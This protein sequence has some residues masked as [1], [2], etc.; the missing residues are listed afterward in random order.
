MT[1]ST[2]H[3]ANRLLRQVPET[4]R[5]LLSGLLE[6]IDLDKGFQLA[7][8]DT[9]IDYVYFLETGVGSIVARSP[10]G[11]EAEAGLFG[12]EGFGPTPPAL[13]IDRNPFDIFV[14]VPGMG[15][16]LPLVTL[17]E[18]LAVSPVFARLL[19]CFA[20]VMS[21]QI[22][23]TGLSNAVHMIDERLARWLLMC[24]DRTDGDEI[25]LTHEFL[26]LMLAVRRPSVTTALHT[27]EGNRFIYASRG[28]VTIRNREKLEEFAVDSYGKPE[29]EYEGLLGKMR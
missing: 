10:E 26:S 19:Q 4:E 29:A 7:R 18:R 6:P 28:H 13:G 9:T 11:H 14:Q 17:R 3:S 12:R 23:H 15:H 27:L 2:I 22:T 5:E 16:R 1:H 25:A 21:V 24:H 8:A 20:Y